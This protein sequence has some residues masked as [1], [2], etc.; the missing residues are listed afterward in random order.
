M[1][2]IALCLNI[3][4]EIIIIRM[5]SVKKIGT[6]KSKLENIINLNITYGN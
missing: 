5:K 4:I 6:I 1:C 2:S 3:I